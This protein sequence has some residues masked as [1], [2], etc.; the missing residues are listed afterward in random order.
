MSV[1]GGCSPIQFFKEDYIKTQDDNMLIPKPIQQQS[2]ENQVDSESV[3]LQLHY[4]NVLMRS[5]GTCCIEWCMMN[6]KPD[7]MSILQRYGTIPV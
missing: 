1:K 6:Y 5:D 4:S 3:G 7:F 2:R